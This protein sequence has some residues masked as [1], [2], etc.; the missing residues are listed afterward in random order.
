MR[1]RALRV[2]DWQRCDL[3]KKGISIVTDDG[4]AV[5]QWDARK[6]S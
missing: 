1:I 6:F 2:A 3:V 4:T 5:A